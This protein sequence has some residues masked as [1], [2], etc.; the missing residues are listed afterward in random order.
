[1][2]KAF[3]IDDDMP[4]IKI[5]EYFLKEY[6]I[7]EIAGCFTDPLTALEQFKEKMPQLVF[8][9]INMHQLNGMD[10]AL[11]IIEMNPDTDIIFT[12]AYDNFAVDAFEIN[13]ADYIVKPIIKARFDKSMERIIKKTQNAPVTNGKLYI[14]CFGK[15]SIYW[16]NKEPIK[17]RTEKSKELAALLIC[18][19]GQEVTRDE[20]IEHLW[21][22]TDMDRAIHYLH[23][24]I[25]YI[26]KSFSDY[27]I[28]RS[29]LKI[30]GNYS[31]V[32][33]DDVECDYERY[34]AVLKSTDKSIEMHKTLTMLCRFDFMEG[35]DWNWAV[36]ERESFAGKCI[37][38]ARS[39]CKYYMENKNYS[40]AELVLKQVYS[41]DPY[42]ETVTA[43]LIKLYVETNQKLKAIKHFNEFSS[44]IKND[45][46][47]HPGKYIKELIGSIS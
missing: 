40:E 11:R 46:G 33:G 9:D 17:W 7:V 24:S 37:D 15:F 47:I 14:R 12:T 6:D 25:Y 29:Y 3:I 45:L 8:L 36:L 26:R 2:L 27:G 31:V 30:S 23:N 39:L 10:T 5:L 18:S 21:A 22:D 42:D 13:A 19:G 28:D 20:I 16:Q 43:M 35:E 32:M 44:L 34:S 38:A 4:S 41:K 1:M